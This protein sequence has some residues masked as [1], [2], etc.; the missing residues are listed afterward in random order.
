MHANFLQNQKLD[1]CALII[2]YMLS[3]RYFDVLP[4][5]CFKTLEC[6]SIGLKKKELFSFFLVFEFDASFLK[7]CGTH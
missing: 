7:C 6:L 4:A 5:F 2:R 3:C 1:M